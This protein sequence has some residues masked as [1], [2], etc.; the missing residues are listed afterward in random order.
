MTLMLLIVCTMQSYGQF[1]NWN[2]IEID[3]DNTQYKDEIVDKSIIESRAMLDYDVLRE[4]DVVW[5]KRVW[6]II[7]TREKINQ[8]LRYPEKPFF[9]TLVEGIAKGELAA[10]E[11]G[12]FQEI[13]SS[14]EIMNILASTDTVEVINPITYEREPQ[15]VRNE[16]NPLSVTRYRIKEVWYF[17]RESSV[18]KVRIL[19]LAPIKEFYD[20]DTGEFKYEAPLF[21]I[22][23]PES[24]DFL[25]RSTVFNEEN[26]AALLTWTDLFEQRKFSSYVYKESNVH[27]MRLGDI[28]PDNG[29]D[30]LM[31]AGRIN[32]ELF[33]WEHDL[34]SY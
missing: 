3:S 32:S 13:L 30:R 21:W 31:E 16:I 12:K 19:G 22:H 4:A 8:P 23:F 34:W 24:R 17:D 6:R 18:M 1:E 29:V 33:N 10:F 28:Y 7:D 9:Q 11:D 27:D 26:D 15:V 14:D 5:E 25:S 2:I 20:D